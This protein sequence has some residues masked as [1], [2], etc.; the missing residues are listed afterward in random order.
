LVHILSDAYLHA[1]LSEEILE[2]VDG[3]RDDILEVVQAEI[4][5][6][7]KAIQLKA[8]LERAGVQNV[9]RS[10]IDW[11]AF[12]VDARKIVLLPADLR[13]WLNEEWQAVLELGRRAPLEGELLIPR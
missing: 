2:R 6:V 12:F 13:T 7:L 10:A 9:A 4:G 3:I 5:G 11:Q 1:R 8:G